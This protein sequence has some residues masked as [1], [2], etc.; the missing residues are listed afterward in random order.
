GPREVLLVEWEGKPRPV[1]M[2]PDTLDSEEKMSVVVFPWFGTSRWEGNVAMVRYKTFQ[3]RIDTDKRVGTLEKVPRED[4]FVHGKEVLQ[5]HVFPE[6][7]VRL[8][9]L[10]AQKGDDVPGPQARDTVLHLEL[11]KGKGGK[12]TL[13]RAI[14][15]GRFV[16]SASPDGKWLAVRALADNTKPDEILLVSSRGE[17]REIA[18]KK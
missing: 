14:R 9:V 17:V 12:P 16:F 8:Q 6:G 5:R 7:G 15:N 3:I 1:R 4:A 18:A 2:G 11:H 10:L 13:L